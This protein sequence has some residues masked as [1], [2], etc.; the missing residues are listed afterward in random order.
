MDNRRDEMTKY[1]LSQKP[2]VMT[3]EKYNNNTP[4]VFLKKSKEFFNDVPLRRP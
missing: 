1:L 2:T 4:M 3:V